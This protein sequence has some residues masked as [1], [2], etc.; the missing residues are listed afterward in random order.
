MPKIFK[1]RL[2]DRQ[3]DLGVKNKVYDVIDI[4]LTSGDKYRYIVE[5]KVLIRVGAIYKVGFPGRIV[6]ENSKE[7]RMVVAQILA[8]ELTDG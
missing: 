8:A 6:P 1:F 7:Y 4:H 3:G 2:P 5:P